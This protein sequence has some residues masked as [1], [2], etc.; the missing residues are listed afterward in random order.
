MTV[1]STGTSQVGTPYQLACQTG[2]SPTPSIS[3]VV[4]EWTSTCSGE[5][6]VLRQPGAA[7][8]STQYFKAVDSGIH[9]CTVTDSVGNQGSTS[10]NV[11][12]TG[13]SAR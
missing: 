4:Y 9:T 1:E 3:P 2:S 12:A 8:V 6:F 5:C 10:V 11:S 7:T 13:K